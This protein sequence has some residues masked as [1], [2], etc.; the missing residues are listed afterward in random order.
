MELFILVLGI[1]YMSFLAYE[2]YKLSIIRKSF[3]HII[4]VN[5]TRG[6]S[7][8]SRLIDA[9]LREGGFKVFTKTTGTSP[10]MLYV[11][12]SEHEIRR[13]GRANIK[14]QIS[15]MKKASRQGAEVLVI[16]CMAIKRELQQISQERILGADISVI[17]NVRMDHLD[18]IG[19]TLNEI[20]EALS[21]VIP[22]KGS[23]FTAD[24]RY[25]AYFKG[26]AGKR[27]STAYLAEDAKGS[28]IGVD[29]GDNVSLALAVCKALDIDE[30]AAIKGMKEY[31]RDPGS[32]RT[33]T[34]MNSRN[35][36]IRLI[37]ALA[38]NDPESTEKILE[39]AFVEESFKAKNIL[40]IN[41][42]NDRMSR[43]QQF[44]DFAG[45]YISRFDAIW[46]S[47]PGAGLMEALLKKKGISR[48]HVRQVKD[49]KE[50]DYIEDDA[51]ILAVGNIAGFGKSIMEY[52]EKAGGI[53]G[54]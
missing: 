8:V 44:A 15:I 20:A 5:G 40:L 4:H 28:N 52:M 30:E 54:G 23:F 35:K 36:Q 45:K 12:G 6:K 31:R 11:D 53:I 47:G 32:L 49:I 14:E 34:I 37:N 51:L 33:Y 50:F 39:T 16:E 25:Y 27:G 18:E 38:A 43:L 41:N 1:S 7:T 17:T 13:R 3:K 46:I 19:R 22:S 10:R 48:D 9:G 21:S 26:I 2:N 42:R 24:K 29:F